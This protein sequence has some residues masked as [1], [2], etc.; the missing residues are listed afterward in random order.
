VRYYAAPQY[1][2]QS[3]GSSD[4]LSVFK[5]GLGFGGLLTCRSTG[6]AVNILVPIIINKIPFAFLSVIFLD[7]LSALAVKRS[8][9]AEAQNPE[10]FETA[11]RA[12]LLSPK[13]QAAARSESPLH[14]MLSPDNGQHQKTAALSEDTLFPP[15]IDMFIF[16][17]TPFHTRNSQSSAIFVYQ[18]IDL[19]KAPSWILPVASLIIYIIE[20]VKYVSNKET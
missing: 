13:A 2:S 11:W 12:S 18:L 8:F 10:L 16:L 6:P 3:E 1:I 14:S 5:L 17:A 4:R 9:L 7:F 19:P 20:H 15:G